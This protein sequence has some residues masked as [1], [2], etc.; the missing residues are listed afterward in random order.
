MRACALLLAML[1]LGL[2]PAPLPKPDPTKTD[3]KLF[4]GKWVRARLVIDGKPVTET[5]TT[6]TITGA[7]MQFPAAEDVWELTLDATRAP[8]TLESRGRGM[9]FYGLY[10]LEGD[11]LTMCCRQGMTAADRP[12]NFDDARAGT[13]VQVFQR[14]KR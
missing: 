7:R 9:T 10:R 11:T 13:W 4:Q 1:S 2:A 3:L 6:I 12:R 5:V 8:K 14:Q